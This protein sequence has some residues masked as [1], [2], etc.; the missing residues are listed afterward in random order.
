MSRNWWHPPCKPAAAHQD[1]PYGIAGHARAPAP[2]AIG[3]ATRALGEIA[4]THR[5]MRFLVELPAIRSRVDS[6]HDVHEH[7]LA[8]R[9]NGDERGC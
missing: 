7:E 5:T 3:L 1:V 9:A 6:R 4:R 8:S 2:S